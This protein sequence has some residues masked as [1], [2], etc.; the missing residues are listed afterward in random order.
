V[1]GVN[2]S[3]CTANF[4]GL[5][6][7]PQKR[8]IVVVS[9]QMQ[10]IGGRVVGTQLPLVAE[11]DDFGHLELSLVQGMLVRVAIEGTAYV[12]EFTVPSTPTFDLLSVMASAPDPFTVQIPLPF[13][14]RRSL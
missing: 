8:S 5:D 11:S 3:T 9:D 14:N 10:N 7:R 2:L 1:P 13:L 4:I 6:G 12:R